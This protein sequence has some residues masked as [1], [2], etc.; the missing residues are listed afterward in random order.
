VGRRAARPSWLVFPLIVKS[1]LEEASA[2]IAQASVVHDDESLQERIRF[3]HDRIRTAAIVEQYIE[4]REVYVGVLGNHRLQVMPVWELF[5]D[6]LP[7]DAARIATHKVKWDLQYQE[8]YSIHIGPAKDLPD[9][10]TRK[11]GEAS[12]RAYRLLG[13]SGYARLDF[14]LTDDGFF[15]FLEANPNPD[16]A[17][18]EE[19]ASSA[20]AA[21]IEYPRLLQRI[22]NLGLR[23]NPGG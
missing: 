15:H 6:K 4:G 1:Q 16:I 19:F 8:R 2:G 11:L 17:S 5:F 20:K 9:E 10:L 13:L 23:W 3:I 12:K 22:L 7:P 14:R 21:G 18:D